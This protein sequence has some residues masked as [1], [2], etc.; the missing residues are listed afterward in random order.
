MHWDII[1]SFW[2][3]TQQLSGESYIKNNKD[4]A[5][6]YITYMTADSEA[7]VMLAI[8]RCVMC[9]VVGLHVKVN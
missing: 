3:V 8:D 4:N 6:E 2:C 7:V 9:Y 1:T 5:H